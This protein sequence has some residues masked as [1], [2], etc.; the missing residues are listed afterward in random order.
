MR[1]QGPVVVSPAVQ[2]EIELRDGFYVLCRCPSIYIFWVESPTIFA[3]FQSNLIFFDLT[4]LELPFSQGFA[5]M[6]VRVALTGAGPVSNPLLW[7]QYM[8]VGSPWKN[9]F[10]ACGALIRAV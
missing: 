7:F 4:S 10:A 9:I 1:C 6:V 2:E 3:L 8:C 5:N